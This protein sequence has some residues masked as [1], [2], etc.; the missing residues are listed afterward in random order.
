MI[1]LR[2]AS[3][4]TRHSSGIKPSPQISRKG[5]SNELIA[6]YKALNLTLR[7][8]LRAPGRRFHVPLFAVRF[9]GPNAAV[10]FWTGRFRTVPDR[11]DHRPLVEVVMI[12]PNEVKD[13]MSK[14]TDAASGV[15]RDPPAKVFLIGFEDLAAQYEIKF[16]LADAR[17]YSDVVDAVRTNVWYELNRC[18]IRLAFDKQEFE[19]IRNLRPARRREADLA[20]L[21]GQPLF[22]SLNQSQLERLGAGSGRIRFGK[23]ERIISQG[24]TGNSMFILV[25]GSAEVW[26][27]REGRTQSVGRL[28]SGD[29]FGEIS[30]LTGEP[31][32]ATI[33]ALIDC[34]VIEIRK[35]PIG[36]LLHEYPELAEAL[37]ETVVARR[38]STQTQLASTPV[39]GN[40][41]EAIATKEGVLRRLRKFFEL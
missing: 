31:R 6:G 2:A 28:V 20:L 8:R 40:D 27:E 21:A 4:S 23:G 24:A 12:P 29:C 25:T 32:T 22:S 17:L 26:V 1:L 33:I 10:L 37:S 34:E 38:Y 41:S 16:S 35:E 15:L 30:F 9:S 36:N 3:R 39:N 18:G 13:A 19:L 11:G 5:R 7:V 14:A